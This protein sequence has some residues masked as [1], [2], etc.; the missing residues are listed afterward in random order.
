MNNKSIYILLSIV[1]DTKQN[2][3][4]D[5]FV[6]L[7][8]EKISNKSNEKIDLKDEKYQNKTIGFYFSAHW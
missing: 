2:N 8:N 3:N 7:L 6:D 1:R 4:M 5:E